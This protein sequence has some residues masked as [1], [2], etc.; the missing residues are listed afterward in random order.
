MLRN[1]SRPRDQLVTARASIARFACT[2]PSVVTLIC[3]PGTSFSSQRDCPV[4]LAT[5]IEPSVN[6]TSTCWPSR[7]TWKCVP[8]AVVRDTGQPSACGTAREVG[9]FSHRLPADMNVSNPEHR[10]HAEEIYPTVTAQAADL[11]PAAM[12]VEKEGAYG[13]AERRTQFWHQ[14]TRSG[15]RTSLESIPITAAR[16]SFKC[17]W[18]MAS[19]IASRSRISRRATRTTRYCDFITSP[20]VQEVGYGETSEPWWRERQALRFVDRSGKAA[21]GFASLQM[22]PGDL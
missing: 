9:T 17:C 21:L 7:C 20:S 5:A 15:P 2:W 12:W 18:R 10:K 19:L 8:R 11:L 16:H 3:S 14:L 13:N 22:Q 4:S 1:T 6:V